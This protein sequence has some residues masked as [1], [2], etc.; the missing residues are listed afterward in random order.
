MGK[1]YTTD[2]SGEDDRKEIISRLT[3][4]ELKVHARIVKKEM[5]KKRPNKD[6]TGEKR[7]KAAI[8]K[9]ENGKK[10]MKKMKAD[11][12]ENEAEESTD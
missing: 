1:H 9:N 10:K 2:S 4:E 12:A 3:F 5:D 11:E 6:T 8:K 7:S